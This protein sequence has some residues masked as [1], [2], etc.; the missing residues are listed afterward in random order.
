MA[1]YC[2]R[3]QKSFTFVS[4]RQQHIR[5]SL[6]HH[7]CHIYPS[8]PNYAT[9]DELDE[10]L[11]DEHNICV[12][13]DKQFNTPR[14]LVQHDVAKHNMCMTCRKYY[15][16]PANRNS[17]M[18]THVEKNIIC[19]GCSSRFSRD[20]AVLLHLEAGTCVSGVDIEDVT[21]LAFDC[22]QAEDYTSYDPDFDFKCPHCQ[23]SF[24]F[25][26]GLLQHAESGCC[27]KLMERDSSLGKFLRF[28]RSCIASAT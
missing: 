18:I 7:V 27:D 20:S 26:S 14:Q 1:S 4:A 2:P 21:Q 16:S 23:T 22:V 24:A 8:P 9:E 15:T 28:V 13:C 19:P 10:H 11:Q 12:T 6:N 17:H 3:C 5:D 25:I